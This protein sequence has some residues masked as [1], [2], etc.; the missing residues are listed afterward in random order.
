[1]ANTRAVATRSSSTRRTPTAQRNGTKSVTNFTP[2]NLRNISGY[3]D[4]AIELSKNP[5]GRV[6]LRT[7]I[8]QYAAS[9][10]IDEDVFADAAM[11]FIDEVRVNSAKPKKAQSATKSLGSIIAGL[12]G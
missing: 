10:G 2:I 3:V 12:I 4:K 8:K 11:N 7:I 6:A 1:M 5:V 9:T